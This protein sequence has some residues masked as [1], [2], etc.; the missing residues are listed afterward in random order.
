MTFATPVASAIARSTTYSLEMGRR[1]ADAPDAATATI[2][3][4]SLGWD[5]SDFEDAGWDTASTAAA[6]AVTV[7]SARAEVV[8]M[9]LEM[10]ARRS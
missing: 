6:L 8:R 3:H 9:D 10:I 2:A 7:E 1:W 5:A 4:R